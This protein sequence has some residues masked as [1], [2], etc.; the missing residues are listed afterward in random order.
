M[1]LLRLCLIIV[2]GLL[3]LGAGLGCQGS[4]SV[5]APDVSSPD[6]VGNGGSV[7]DTATS[8]TTDEAANGPSS[9]PPGPAPGTVRVRATVA[10]CD[11]TATPPHCRI[12]IEEVLA[13]GS[14]TPPI[15]SGEQS[16]RVRP[17]L[18]D[19]LREERAKEAPL[20]LVLRHSGDRP[21]RNDE[22]PAKPPLDWILHAVERP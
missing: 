20:L 9:L 19:R 13:Y 8:D 7:A 2:G 21:V 10:S 12:G 17:P 18:P 11:T 16:V 6:T 3:V 14:G 4:E 5:P 22:P 1:S 15:G